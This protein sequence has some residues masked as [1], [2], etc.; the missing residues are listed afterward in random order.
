M[1][2]SACLSHPF[3]EK[4]KVWVLLPLLPWPGVALVQ[5][6]AD[7]PLLS[8][9]AASLLLLYLITINPQAFLRE[10]HEQ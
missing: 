6:T 8:K 2:T 5:G 9:A 3:P 10:P 7:G 1:L 4:A